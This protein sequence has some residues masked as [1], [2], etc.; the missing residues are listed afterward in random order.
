VSGIRVAALPALLL[1]GLLAGCGADEPDADDASAG[2]TDVASVETDL[3]PCP[4]Q[5]DRPA[6]GDQLTG[7]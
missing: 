7:V 4:D 3:P 2:P 1:I 6:V 5:P